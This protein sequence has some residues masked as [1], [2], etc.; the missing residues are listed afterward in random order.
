M[1][2]LALAALV[3]LPL[4]LA[5]ATASPTISGRAE[6][7]VLRN[8][9]PFGRH[10]IVVSG[11]GDSLRAQSSV[12]LRAGLGPVVMFRLEQTC[13]ETW[14]EGVLSGMRC[15]TLKDGRRTLVRAVRE[16]DRLRVTGADGETVFPATALPA[17]WW[18]MPPAGATLI[19]TETGEP[20]RARVTHMGRETISVGG[21]RIEADRVRVTGSVSG[22]LWYDAEGRWVACTFRARGQNIEYRL[23]TPLAGAPA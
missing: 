21:R 7:D 11:S 22:D 16:G 10:T 4:A 23:A 8:G 17:S 18:T 15:S 1:R 5:T 13:A 6:F 12:A 14:S 2:S 9:E 20:M 19:N 3:A